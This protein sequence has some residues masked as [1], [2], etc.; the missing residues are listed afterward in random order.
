MEAISKKYNPIQNGA[1]FNGIG[2]MEELM[3]DDVNHFK[4]PYYFIN[5]SDD[6][7]EY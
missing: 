1:N 5:S 2:D 7:I 3:I 4:I 6:V